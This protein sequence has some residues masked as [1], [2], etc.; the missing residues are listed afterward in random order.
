MQRLDAVLFLPYL[1]DLVGLVGPR[2]LL[3]RDEGTVLSDFHKTPHLILPVPSEI[4]FPPI[5][6]MGKLR[7]RG[8]YWKLKMVRQVGGEAAV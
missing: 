7:L 8:L 3:L 6:Q 1:Y 2:R 4:F 5:F